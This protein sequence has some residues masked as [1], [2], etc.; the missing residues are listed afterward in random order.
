MYEGLLT[1]IARLQA[2]RQHIQDC[3]SFRRRTKATLQEIEQ[4]AVTARYDGRDVRETHF[5]VV[6]FLD[7]VVLHSDDSVRSEWARNTLQE[8]LFGQTDAGVVFFDKLE[9]FRSRRDSEQLANILEVYL[10]C[11]LL[12]FEGR[13]SGGFRAELESIAEKVRRRIEDIRGPS[14]RISPFGALPPDQ[15]SAPAV[16]GQGA[17]RLRLVAL[18]AIIFAILCFLALKLSLILTSGHLLSR[19]R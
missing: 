17:N 5:A 19:L 15:T 10:L 6:A 9:A 7:S 14:R 2:G 1:G 8:E 3:E 12:G 13:Y 16:K 18:G 11:L 4:A